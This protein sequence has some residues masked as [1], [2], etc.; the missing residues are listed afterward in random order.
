MEDARRRAELRCPLER[1][2]DLVLSP[3]EPHGERLAQ[4]HLRAH[5][6]RDLG[7]LVH[8]ARSVDVVV[9]G[10]YASAVPVVEREESV[11]K[12]ICDISFRL[13]VASA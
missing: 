9:R 3:E 1:R 2:V 4:W 11:M 10:P 5:H 7:P 6:L 12:V 8:S 13:D